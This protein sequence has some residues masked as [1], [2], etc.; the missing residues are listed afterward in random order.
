MEFK[1]K[2]LDKFQEDAIAT[3]NRNHSCV[4]S[5]ST[6]T[7]KTLIAEYVIHK[8]LPEGNTIV[9]T[10][11]IKALSNQKY[12]DF[13]ND[14][15]KEKVGLLT[16]DHSINP[17]APILIMTTEIYRNMLVT[18]DPITQRVSY[19]VFDEIHYI[20]DIERG[21]VWEESIIFS[22]EHIRFLA[23]SATIPNYKEFAQWIQTIKNHKVETVFYGHRPV[24]LKHLCYDKK[25]GLTT[26]QS[27]KADIALEE[28]QAYTLTGH[29]KQY[30]KKKNKRGLYDMKPP[31]HT[32]VIK[33]IKTPAMYFCFSRKKCQDFA[34]E[35]AKKKDLLTTQ[36]S[37]E[38]STFVRNHMQQEF[39]NM[40]T[41]KILRQTLPKG[42]GFH[43][44]GMLPALKHIVEE[45]FSKGL[46]KILYTTE[47]FSVGINMP[48]KTVIFDAL[49]KYDG[50]T[51]RPLH[52]KEYFQIAGRAGRRGI[53]KE[54]TVIATINR[55][56][57]DLDKLKKISTVDDEP[58]V[59]QFT[60][61]TNT[62]LNLL[63]NFD[64][65]T[66]EKVLKS[67]FDY[68]TR[69]QANK[70]A[71]HVMATFKNKMKLLTKLEY[72][73]PASQTTYEGAYVENTQAYELTE[74][75]HF[76]RHL[77]S[78]EITLT[79]LFFLPH[80]HKMSDIDLLTI[81]ATIIYES[82]RLDYFMIKGS[83]KAYNRILKLLEKTRVARD[84]NK[85]SLKR[86]INFVKAWATGATFAQLMTYS[87]MAEG[88]II[89]FF[90]R[91]IDTLTQL[92]HATQNEELR[93]TFQKLISLIDRDLVSA[94]I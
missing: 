40:D 94:D 57:T 8:H 20:N 42:I 6:G 4:V 3:I 38:A 21:T 75:G 59:S 80:L 47:T 17:T 48:A 19:V 32:E 65:K 9:Y 7:G 23:L 92:Q 74:K 60:L 85:I 73:K 33:D 41:T 79:E 43:H 86:M 77:Y 18:N 70:K 84:I 22:P 93:N 63:A 15:G 81:L 54:G 49:E 83:E 34:F 1:G 26:I 12:K 56:Y 35:T 31:H 44:S 58:I 71:V 5:A 36:E 37:Q 72:I 64:E 61:S 91:L 2:T 11:P 27:I 39:A 78:N 52:A 67:S 68:Y 28:E 45:L 66:Q 14:Y 51:T 30:G 90:R 10:A 25:L 76:A 50:I 46:I 53:D 87:N 13:C 82:R 24:P 69:T 16:G 62:V 55:K 88:D 89:R 29:K